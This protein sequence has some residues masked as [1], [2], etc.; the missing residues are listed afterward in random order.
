MHAVPE[1]ISRS[2]KLA[3]CLGALLG[4]GPIASAQSQ[5]GNSPPVDETPTLYVST[6]DSVALPDGLSDFAGAAWSTVQ[7]ETANHPRVFV[8]PARLRS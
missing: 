2:L 6:A 4:I 7:S 1:T 5:P 3:L 8:G